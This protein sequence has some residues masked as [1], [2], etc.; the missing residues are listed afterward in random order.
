[1]K[2]SATHVSKKLIIDNN[3]IIDAIQSLEFSRPEYWSGYPF[4][5]PGD[6]S[7]PGVEP[8]SLALQGDSFTAEPQGKLK[9]T[10]V[11]SLSVLQQIFPTQESNWGLLHYR[12]ILYQLSYHGSPI[13]DN[14][15]SK[16]N[17]VQLLIRPK[18]GAKRSVEKI[19]YKV[20]LVD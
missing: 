15:I 6:L 16:T 3:C 10:G 12:W 13:I 18:E 5:F 1:M 19:N 2:R 9:N 11:G 7:N 17:E 20:M 8:R 4:P 14:S